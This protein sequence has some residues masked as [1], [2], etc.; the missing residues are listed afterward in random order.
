MTVYSTRHSKISISYQLPRIGIPAA[1]SF[2]KWAMAALEQNNHQGFL[3]IRIVDHNEGRAL[4]HRY[5][6]KSYATN[7]LSF[8]ID[9]PPGLPK[10]L[11]HSLLGDLVICAPVIAQEAQEQHKSLHAHYAHMIIHGTLHL[12][13]IDHKNSDEAAYMEHIE[14]NL[15]RRFAIDNP[16]REY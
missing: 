15:L 12:L 2:R 5:R 3:A 11:N 13:G 9:L 1:V 4:N 14:R 6:N 16:Y 7:V 8:P 10:D